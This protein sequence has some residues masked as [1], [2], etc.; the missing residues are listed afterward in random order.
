M[1]ESKKRVVAL[2][3]L[4]DRFNWEPEFF[5]KEGKVFKYVTRYSSHSFTQVE[6]VREASSR[7]LIV[8]ALLAELNK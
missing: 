1:K 6:E 5:V 8:E 7:D 2:N 3:Y 4:Y